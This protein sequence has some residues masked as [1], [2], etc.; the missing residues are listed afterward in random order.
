MYSMF[1]E[2]FRNTSHS[3]FT[4]QSHPV[5]ALCSF[6]EEIQTQNFNIYNITEVIIRT[7]KYIYVV[8]QLNK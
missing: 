4:S 1:S 7:H 5:R 8:P 6:G 3:S 2:S